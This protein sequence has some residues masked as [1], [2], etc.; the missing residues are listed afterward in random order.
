[1]EIEA[2]AKN[3]HFDLRIFVRVDVSSGVLGSLSNDDESGN[4]NDKK[5]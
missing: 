2:K 1:M 5:A 4:E 3:W